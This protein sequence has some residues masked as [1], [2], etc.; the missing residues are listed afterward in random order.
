[1]GF[2][3]VLW[4]IVSCQLWDYSI[5]QATL[6]TIFMSFAKHQEEETANVAGVSYDQADEPTSRREDDPIA[7]VRS[8][9]QQSSPSPPMDLEMGWMGNRQDG[10]AASYTEIELRDR[11][12]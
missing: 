3:S 11:D 7:G 9:S 10:V 1:M 12:E 4:S 6:E 5:S 8:G 2:W